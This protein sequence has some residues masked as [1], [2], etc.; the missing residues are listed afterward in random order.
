MGADVV[1]GE[2]APAGRG[3]GATVVTSDE[4]SMEPVDVGAEMDPSSPAEDSADPVDDENAGLGS[5][6]TGLLQILLQ[7]GT[8]LKRAFLPPKLK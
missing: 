4:L 6:S 5:V 2:G 8:S 3:V 1:A 7:C